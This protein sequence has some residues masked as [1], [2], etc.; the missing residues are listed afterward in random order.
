[1]KPQKPIAALKLSQSSDCHTELPPEHLHWIEEHALSPFDMFEP[2]CV[3]SEDFTEKHGWKHVHH[4]Q[5]APAEQAGA[6][7][8]VSREDL[9][10]HWATNRLSRAWSCCRS[11]TRTAA[12]TMGVL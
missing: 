2:R 6:P 11:I 7:S 3:K 12:R 1:L 8:L 10:E 9:R 5:V 4:P